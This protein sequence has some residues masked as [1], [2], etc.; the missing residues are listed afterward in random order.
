[1]K[2]SFTIG[3]RRRDWS[4]PI[5]NWIFSV[6]VTC[7][8]RILLAYDRIHGRVRIGAIVETPEVSIR[9][10]SIPSAGNL[11]D[12]VLVQ[13]VSPPQR[14][15]LLICHGIGE[16]VEHWTSVQRLLAAYGIASLVF[17]Y[18][19]YGR[20]SGAVTAGQCEQNAISAFRHLQDSIP[21]LPVSVLGFSMGSGVA[22]AIL[23]RV[24]VHR[25]VL[26]ASFPSFQ[27]AARAVGWPDLLA[28][29]VPDIWRTNDSLP[30]CGVPALLVHGEQDELFPSQMARDLKSVCGEAVELIVISGLSHGE[31]F[32]HP[33]AS[34]W[35][36]VADFLLR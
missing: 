26:G 31:P 19:G 35:G 17:D 30:K 13:P 9:R 5:R 16:I 1:V 29:L 7:I 28:F 27:Q 3:S 15:A 33:H 25:L 18:A 14:A 11:L 6:T 4:D 8:S 34:Y 24:L 36:P 2:T 12:G 22:A 23:D 10:V 32:Y 21:A 20:S